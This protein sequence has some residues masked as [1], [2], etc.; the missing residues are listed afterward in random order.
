MGTEIPPRVPHPVPD[1]MP[2]RS[3]PPSVDNFPAKPI[4][5]PTD[6]G[7]RG[8]TTLSVGGVDL[9]A[10]SEMWGAG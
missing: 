10:L 4:D 8:C 2:N 7:L 5:A 9:Y 1:P 6:C 3:L